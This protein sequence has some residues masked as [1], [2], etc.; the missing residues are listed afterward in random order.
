[1][2]AETGKVEQLAVMGG[3]E[4]PSFL[5]IDPPGNHLYAVTE[6]ANSE[7]EGVVYA[8]SING[9]G[10]LSL[11]NQRF[12]GG[13]D[14]CHLAVDATDSYVIVANYIGGS[15]C[16]LPIS[17]DGRLGEKCDFIQHEGSSVNVERQR[18]AHAHSVTIDHTNSWAYVCD[19]G[20]D[21][22]LV[23]RINHEDQRLEAE[24]A[25]TV[26]AESGQ[27]PRHFD[28]HPS[29]Q[30][31]YVINELGSTVSVYDHDHRSGQMTSKQLISTLPD[32]W[33]GLKST[34][35]IHVSPDG[36]FLYGSNRGHHSIAMFAIDPGSGELTLIGCEPTRGKT[37]RNFAIAPGG[38]FILA[39]NQDSGDIV[40]F[41]V[42]EES[43]RLE[44]TGNQLAIP[45]PVCIKFNS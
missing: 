31:C 41:A 8:Y 37:P 32:G 25:L 2:D 29:G 18:E 10:S 3:I 11:L 40:T 4:D 17:P 34:A 26:Q 30:Y 36:R 39:A 28:I 20:M 14:P 9:D 12:T 16:M 5:T 22:I 15:V 44:F 43:G 6:T 33:K 35:D 27:G 19:L 13:A 24:V 38:R 45:A 7:G 1:M 42:D 21:R 23:Y